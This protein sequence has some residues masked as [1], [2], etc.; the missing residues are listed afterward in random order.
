[1]KKYSEIKWSEFVR[2]AIRQRIM[3]L[4]KLEIDRESFEL[5]A[6]SEESLRESWDD[7]REDRWN[8]V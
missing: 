7:P 2:K 3:D 6:A 8:Y 5:M 1:M 4:E